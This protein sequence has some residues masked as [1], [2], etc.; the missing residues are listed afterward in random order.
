MYVPLR[1]KSEPSSASCREDAGA[2]FLE[3][4]HG[5]EGSEE[6]E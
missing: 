6:Q 5:F 1:L 3:R 2:L 4:F